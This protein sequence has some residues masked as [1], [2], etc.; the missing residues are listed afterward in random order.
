[1]QCHW[2]TQHA[3]RFA[4]MPGLLSYIQNHAVLNRAGLPLLGDPGFDIFSEIEFAGLAQLEHATQSDYFCK[5]VVPDERRLL[6]ETR[7]TFLLVKRMSVIGRPAPQSFKLVS[8][9]TTVPPE[10]GQSP[11]LNE[12][13]KSYSDSLHCII[14][15][16]VDE[17]RGNSCKTV[18]TVDQHYFESLAAALA[19]HASARSTSNGTLVHAVIA[20]ELTVVRRGI[21]AAP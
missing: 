19:Y 12:C 21:L 5:V 20:Q 2:K 7:R 14:R 10:D 6:D 8:F 4:K 17:V 16:A 1:M 13:T 9:L 15:Y 18:A 3:Q 11:S